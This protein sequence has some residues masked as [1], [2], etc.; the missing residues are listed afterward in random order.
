V[1]HCGQMAP[2]AWLTLPRITRTMCSTAIDMSSNARRVDGAS[3]AL[4]KEIY[5]ARMWGARQIVLNAN[6]IERSGVFGHAP[7]Y[8]VLTGRVLA[9]L[10][11][12]HSLVPQDHLLAWQLAPI[13]S[14]TVLLQGRW[15]GQVSDLTGERRTI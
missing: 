2:V 10:S 5:A 6:R 7:D 9:H 12:S 14:L 15:C 1:V 8:M 4:C 11:A 13:A 3:R